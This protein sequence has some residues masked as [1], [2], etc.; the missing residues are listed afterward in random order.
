MFNTIPLATSS[1]GIVAFHLPS[2]LE[3]GQP[4]ISSLRL[5]WNL[6]RFK[7]PTSQNCKFELR[8]FFVDM[9][10]P[11]RIW[12][13]QCSCP[14]EARICSNLCHFG[15]TQSSDVQPIMSN[16]GNSLDSRGQCGGYVK[17][18][19]TE[20]SY[21]HYDVNDCELK[22]C[23]ENFVCAQLLKARVSSARHSPPVIRL[24]RQATKR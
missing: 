16:S 21:S 22:T 13:V 18:C 12:L 4:L 14:Q 6:V 1:R 11:M 7:Y 24:E 5:G 2:S 10:E 9:N 23:W 8:F 17:K 15:P 20:S 19:G 3:F